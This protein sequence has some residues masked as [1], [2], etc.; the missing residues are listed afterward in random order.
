MLSKNIKRKAVLAIATEVICL[1]LLG[2]FLRGMQT[3]L[4]VDDQRKNTEEKIKEMGSLLEGAKEAAGQLTVSFDD[5]YKS[6]ADSLS[7]MYRSQVAD[8]Y[9]DARIQQYCE[10]LEVTNALI[11][12][13]Q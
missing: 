13:R 10:L 4:S 1:V 11:I 6:K 5:I 3:D 9:T 12:D 7:Y 2:F 8:E